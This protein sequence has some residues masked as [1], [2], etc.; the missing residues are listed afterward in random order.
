LQNTGQVSGYTS[1]SAIEQPVALHIRGLQWVKTSSALVEH[2]ISASSPK[3]DI[4]T[5]MSTRPTEPD[6]HTVRRI[7]GCLEYRAFLATRFS[8]CGDSRS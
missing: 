4:C 1:H 5:F 7:I 2:K 6:Q 3:A 8:E